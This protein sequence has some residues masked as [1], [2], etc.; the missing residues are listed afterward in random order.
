MRRRFGHRLLD[1]TVKERLDLFETRR[2]ADVTEQ[3]SNVV[4]VT[5]AKALDQAN[6]KLSVS[7]QTVDFS[8]QIELPALVALEIDDAFLF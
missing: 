7:L 8:L 1:I 2:R 3:L 5:G 6:Q 4:L